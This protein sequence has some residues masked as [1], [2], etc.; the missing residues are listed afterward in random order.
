[1]QQ[2]LTLARAAEYIAGLAIFLDL[3][4]V[5]A[6]RFPAADLTRILV[7]HAAAQVIAA[8]PLK[9]AARIVGMEPAFAPPFRQ[10]L[11][12]IDAEK[13]ERPVALSR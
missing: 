12:G 13:I 2:R 1:M 11:A 4:D 3:P 7:R 6:D 10:R 5:T 8:I 9:P